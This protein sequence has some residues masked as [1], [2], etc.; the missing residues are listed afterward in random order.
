MAKFDRLYLKSQVVA[1]RPVQTQVRIVGRVKHPDYGPERRQ[2]RWLFDPILFA[3][4]PG[5]RRDGPA[6][7]VLGSFDLLHVRVPGNR[8]VNHLQQLPA[9]VIER[10]ELERSAAP[11]KLKRWIDEPDVPTAVA[12]RVLIAAGEGEPIWSSKLSRAEA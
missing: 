12:S 11:Y 3:E 7:A 1:E 6:Q 9:A 5:H 4:L 2:Y 8:L 10:I